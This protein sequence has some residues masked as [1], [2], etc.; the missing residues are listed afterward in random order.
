MAE[1]DFQAGT[2]R[3]EKEE[4]GDTQVSR[5]HLGPEVHQRLLLQTMA[6][7][8]TLAGDEQPALAHLERSWCMLEELEGVITAGLVAEP[9]TSACRKTHSTSATYLECRTLI[10]YL[11]QNTSSTVVDR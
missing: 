8:S 1:M 9:T 2:V 4:R 10:P 7:C 5:V 3:M 6:E 11:E